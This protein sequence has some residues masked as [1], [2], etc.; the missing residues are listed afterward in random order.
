MITI[1]TIILFLLFLLPLNSLVRNT[2]LDFRAM[3]RAPLNRLFVSHYELNIVLFELQVDTN[4]QFISK[5][6]IKYNKQLSYSLRVE[7]LEDLRGCKRFVWELETKLSTNYQPFGEYI[8]LTNTLFINSLDI[9]S[10]FS[11]IMCEIWWPKEITES[12]I[13]NQC[14]SLCRHQCRSDQCGRGRGERPRPGYNMYLQLMLL[15]HLSNL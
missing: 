9:N 14:A 3:L 15:L 12:E 1:C 10:I 5:S 4:L 2:K 8:Q 7:S 13:T 6:F 11:T